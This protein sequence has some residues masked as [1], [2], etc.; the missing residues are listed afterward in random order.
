MF[1]MSF[2]SLVFQKSRHILYNLLNIVVEHLNFMEGLKMGW[3]I[4]MF[5]IF[6]IFHNNL[7][8][9]TFQRIEI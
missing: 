7:G 5:T 4:T 6:T 3:K 1:E 2:F 8:N 9:K